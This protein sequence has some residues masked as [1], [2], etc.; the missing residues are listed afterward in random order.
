MLQKLLAFIKKNK[1][2][3][4]I[5]LAV[6]LYVITK[7]IPEEKVENKQE[8]Q[9]P[10]A[11]IWNSITLG[12]STSENVIEKLGQPLKTTEQE[13]NKVLNYKSK[14]PNIDN[15][16]FVDNNENKVVLIKEAIASSE[17]RN[18]KEITDKFGE[19]NNIF[20]EPGNLYSIP[21]YYFYVYPDK[22]IAYI[23]HITTGDL[24]EIWYFKPTTKDEF[25]EF[26]DSWIPG[27]K[28]ADPKN[29]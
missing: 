16:V 28:Q 21:S 23:G 25:E 18:A 17:E 3:L 15:Q 4:L 22:G 19:S 12:Q 5:I 14:N 29:L 20:Y 26:K 8:T 13:T 7:F 27:F 1:L 6:V 11:V 24:L 9:I 2:V 10:Q